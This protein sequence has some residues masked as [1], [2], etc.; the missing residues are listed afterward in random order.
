MRL[1]TFDAGDGGRAG[2]L[3]GDKVVDAWALL[4]EPHRGGLR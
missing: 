4:G 3:E 2:V 1:V